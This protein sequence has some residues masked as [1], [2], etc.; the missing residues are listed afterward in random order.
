MLLKPLKKAL[1]DRDN[2]HAII[3]GSAINHGGYTPS[4]TAPSVKQEAQV[5]QDAWKD[6]GI[7]PRTIGYIEAHGTGTKLG[8]PIEINALR[9]VFKDYQ[10]VKPFCAVGSAKAH[11]GHTEG[12]AGI[13][14][15]IK[16]IMSLKKGEIPAMP[17][18]ENLNPY[19]KLEDSPIYINRKLEEWKPLNGQPRRAGISSFGFGGSYAHVVVEEFNN[20]QYS[21]IT[22]NAMPQIFVLSARNRERLRKHAEN[23]KTF[24]QNNKPDTSLLADIAYTLQIGRES[25]EERLAV[26]ARDKDEL[27]SGLTKFLEGNMNGDRIYSGSSNKVNLEAQILIN[28]D[29]A[30]EMIEKWFKKGKLDKLAQLWV[31]GMQLDW[32]RLSGGKSRRIVSL[33]TYPFE[34]KRYWFTDIEK[35]GLQKAI[36]SSKGSEFSENEKA[37]I[38]I[39][40]KNTPVEAD[41]IDIDFKWDQWEM[42]SIT[43]M[44]TV[45]E[46]LK[47][48][49]LQEREGEGDLLLEYVS[50]NNPSIKELAD[51]INKRGAKIGQE[52]IEKSPISDSNKEES[53]L[54]DDTDE[55]DTGLCV[56]L[57][58]IIAENTGHNIEDLNLDQPLDE[59]GT[60]SVINVKIARDILNEFNY[61]N[62]LTD[63]GNE[64]IRYL[65][66]DFSTIGGL[67]DF[68]KERRFSV[69]KEKTHFSLHEIN[70]C[71]KNNKQNIVIEA[72]QADEN[73][74]EVFNCKLIIDETHPFFFDHELDHVS[75][76]QLLEGMSQLTRA[77]FLYS[78]GTSPLTPLFIPEIN[79]SY[80]GYCVKEEESWAKATLIKSNNAGYHFS[81]EIIQNNTKTASGKFTIL[82]NRFKYEHTEDSDLT[83]AGEF[84]PCNQLIVNKQ[85]PLNVLISDVINENGDIGCYFIFQPD[86]PYFNDFKGEYIDSVVLAE[87]CRQSFR[88]FG[89]YFSSQNQPTS[90]ENLIPVLKSIKIKIKRPLHKKERIFLKKSKY[91]VINVGNNSI[92]ELKGIITSNDL[93]Q[94]SFEIQSL[95]L[96]ESYI[97]NN[98]KDIKIPAKGSR[99]QKANKQ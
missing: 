79:V 93:K 64:L 20:G 78:S 42:D 54:Q 47:L 27:V 74:H 41:S 29:D 19:I 57:Q 3:K 35:D 99:K 86:N 18:F 87:A 30:E 36:T 66:S 21:E 38:D 65:A 9:M 52:S 76:M 15:V 60:D 11:I 56:L 83:P 48:S 22:E 25:M 96:E 67:M 62:E 13:T 59:L 14:G 6:A 31:N 61:L 84:A 33:P 44:K 95:L 2:I 24:I 7:D 49:G 46:I 4:I 72:I 26:I 97:S 75:G 43:S 8:D 51:Y 81:A 34:G 1:E 10:D 70:L 85:N 69:E 88:A 73:N 80:H 55:T 32:A 63:A 16:A 68:I 23:I 91:D 71:Q 5:I 92:L 77:G 53:E 82:E 45:F 39:I 37:L 89:Y 17:Y 40:Q 50:R 90:S 98:L 28:D 94:G 12:A 58:K